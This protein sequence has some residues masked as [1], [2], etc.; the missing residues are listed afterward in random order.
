MKKYRA[1]VSDL[2]G[3]L[4]GLDHIPSK[5]TKKIVKKVIEKGIKFYIATGRN[6]N[7]TKII[8]DKLGIKIPLITSNG[9]MVYDE[10]GKLIKEETINQKDVETILSIDY[11]KY[12]ANIIQNFYCGNNWYTRK[13]GKEQILSTIDFDFNVLPK[14]ITHKKII[15]KKIHKIFYFGEPQELKKLEEELLSKMS[16]DVALI[17][18]L[19]HCMEIFS[20]KANKAIAAKFLLEKENIGLDE[21]VSFGDGENDFEM[22]TMVGKGFAM[23]NSIDRLKKLLP[24]DFEFVGENTEDGEA[25]KLQELFLERA[26]NI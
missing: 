26:K 10:N 23:G 2:D 4:L 1:V 8:I 16:E 21:V 20:K 18:V 9:A 17:Y 19:D 22:L 15:D 3:T 6:Y 13:G 14:E 7:Q 5:Y 12:G 11:K 25:V 24:K